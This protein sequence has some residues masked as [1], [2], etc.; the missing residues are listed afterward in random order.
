MKIK[1]LRA[2]KRFSLLKL[3]GYASKVCN[4]MTAN[5]A[6]FVEPRPSDE[7]INGAIDNCNELQKTVDLAEENLK[8]AKLKLK[9]GTRELANLL[10]KRADY[11]EYVADGDVQLIIDSGFD[12]TSGERN[13]TGNVTK[14]DHLRSEFTGVSGQIKLT[15]DSIPN[16]VSYQTYVKVLETEEGDDSPWKAMGMSTK[17]TFTLKELE[18]GKR[19]LIKVSAF[20]SNGEGQASDYIDRVIP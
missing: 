1:I 12:P 4:S 11:V 2:F 14:V 15:W 18:S 13:M 8:N 3:I 17:S 19:T 16:A 20:N 10:D 6:K 7:A 9:E 5:A